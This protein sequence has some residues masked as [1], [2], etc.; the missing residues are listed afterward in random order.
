M[1]VLLDVNIYLSYLLK[2]ETESAIARVV[3]AGILGDYTPVTPKALWD[4]LENVVQRKPYLRERITPEQ[5]HRFR[6]IIGAVAELTPE[7]TAPIP[8]VTRDP[9]DDYLLA[10]AV[11][12]DV[13]YL[14][15]GD[16]DLLALREISPVRILTPRAFVRVLEQ[17][18]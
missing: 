1:R 15:T 16:E 17:S 3:E 10:H 6:S 14:V 8:R 2:P 4:E 18:P 13:D 5:M 9:K 12:D 11:L 7:I